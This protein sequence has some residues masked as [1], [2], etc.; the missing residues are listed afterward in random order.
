MKSTP[1]I[2]LPVVILALCT[3]ATTTDARTWYVKVDGTGDVPTIRQK[4]DDTADVM[5]PVGALTPGF[6]EAET[7]LLVKVER[8]KPHVLIVPQS[9]ADPDCLCYRHGKDE[10]VVIVRMVPDEVNSTRGSA[11]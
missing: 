6:V 2:T 5:M 11:D 9:N 8:Q 1:A 4:V 7:D 10:A 3:L